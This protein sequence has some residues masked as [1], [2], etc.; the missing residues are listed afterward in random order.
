MTDHTFCRAMYAAT[1]TDAGIKQ[2]AFRVNGVT[3]M[4]THR[5]FWIDG[6]DGFKWEGE[7]HCAY[8]AKSDAIEA[9]RCSKEVA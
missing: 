6:P 4:F 1:C 9:W 8:D 7:A 2:N 3:N 5:Y